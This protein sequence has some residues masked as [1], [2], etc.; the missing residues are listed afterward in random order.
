[1]A[2]IYQSKGHTNRYNRESEE[3]YIKRLHRFLP[4]HSYDRL[5]ADRDYYF[6][7]LFEATGRL[8]G[9]FGRRL[10]VIGIELLRRAKQESKEGEVD[11]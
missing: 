7:M 3:D 4:L 5:I 10:A 8:A 11:E 9:I 2:R 1:M 6:R